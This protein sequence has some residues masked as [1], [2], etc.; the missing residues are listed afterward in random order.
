MYAYLLLGYF[1]RLSENN[2]LHTFV[3]RWRRQSNVIRTLTD[4]M[5]DYKI[6]NKQKVIYEPGYAQ[7]SVKFSVLIKKVKKIKSSES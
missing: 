4:K 6:T 7:K 2:P 1:N 3:E 5:F